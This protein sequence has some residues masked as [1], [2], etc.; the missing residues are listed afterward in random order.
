MVSVL[1]VDDEKLIRDTLLHDVPWHSLGIGTVFEANDGKQALEMM[2]K[3]PPDIVVT[4]IKMPHM[5]GIALAQRVRECFP[6]IRFV[7]L[8][9]HTDK[10][11]LK[12]AN[13]FRRI[14][15]F[16]SKVGRRVCQKKARTKSG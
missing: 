4:D 2:Q 9:G 11:Y 8:S 15:S 5:D 13:R 12:E 3:T 14:W 7:F 10:E 16:D 6:E 1:V